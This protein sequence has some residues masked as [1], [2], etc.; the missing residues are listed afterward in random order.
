MTKIELLDG[1]LES[2]PLRY[3]W[4]RIDTRES[5]INT[6]FM[7]PDTRF[8]LTMSDSVLN[9]KMILTGSTERGPEGI[10]YRID[11]WPRLYHTEYRV[12]EDMWRLLG[13]RLRSLEENGIHNERLLTIEKE[14]RDAL[15]QARL[16]LTGKTYDRFM[17]AA[18]R[19]WA[20][21]SLSSAPV[22]ST[23]LARMMY[24][25]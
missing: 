12:A 14:G 9:K 13:P 6:L 19:S 24:W 3:W 10:G 1:R 17:A 15:E 5:T 22:A 20:L 7:E 2:P 16:A 4:S 11:D 21:A 8:K 25:R 23:R 18:T